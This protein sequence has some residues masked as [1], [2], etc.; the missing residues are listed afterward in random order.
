MTALGRLLLLEGGASTAVICEAKHVCRDS[1]SA[2]R[3]YPINQAFAG[4][5]PYFFAVA[6]RGGRRRH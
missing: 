6:I 1:V 5:V 3:V 2:S 4:L